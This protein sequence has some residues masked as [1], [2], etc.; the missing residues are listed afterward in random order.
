MLP[1]EALDMLR[2]HRNA[3][4]IHARLLAE[5]REMV[6]ELPRALAVVLARQLAEAVRAKLPPIESRRAQTAGA[7]GGSAAG[8]TGGQGVP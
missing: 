7:Q 1:G 3:G 2:A 4:A 6:D 5:A 8:A